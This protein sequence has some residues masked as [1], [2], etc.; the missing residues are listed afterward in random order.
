MAITH[1]GPKCHRPIHLQCCTQHEYISKKHFNDCKMDLHNH[2]GTAI[3]GRRP[4]VPS[5]RSQQ[6][7]RHGVSFDNQASTVEGMWL[8]QCSKVWTYPGHER[9]FRPQHIGIT[10]YTLA[11]TKAIEETIHRLQPTKSKEKIGINVFFNFY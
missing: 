10:K 6:R 3:A 2:A 4:Y 9:C 8:F 7:Q 1:T 5:S 11:K